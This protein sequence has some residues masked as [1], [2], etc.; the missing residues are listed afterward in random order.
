MKNIIEMYKINKI[1]DNDVYANKDIDFSVSEGEVHALVG[2]N[3]AGKSTLM[4]IL[5][6]LEKPSSGNIFVDGKETFFNSPNDAID[7]GIGMVHQNFMLIPSFTVAQNIVLAHEPMKNGFIDE[8]TTNE[9]A[10]KLSE[11][12][13]L[14]IDYKSKVSDI[15]VAEKQRTEILK[16][17][18]RNP[19]V[20]IFDEPTAV[21]TPQETISLFDALTSLV[22]IG[23]TVIFI[24]HKL[25]EVKSISHRVT[26]MRSGK[27][28][29]T[30][31]TKDVS[32]NDL[33]EMMVGRKVLFNLN[34]QKA[35][36]KETIIDVKN[37]VVAD[38]NFRDALKG[39]SFSIKAGEILGV[40]GVEGNGQRE[41]V[42]AITG[43]RKIKSGNIIIDGITLANNITPKKVRE[44]KVA[45]IP[46]DRLFNG[47]SLEASIKENLIIDRLYDEEFS[48]YSV[49]K[50][51]N[52]EDNALLSIKNFHI[53][54]KDTDTKVA[55]LSG[56]NM[57]KVIVA[58]EFTSNSKLL[59]VS[60]LT[61]G[62]D[63]GSS[64]YIREKLFEQSR[65]GCAILLVSADLAE[66]MSLSDRIITLHN[67]NISGEFDNSETID[68]K[69]LGLYM[70]GVKDM[71][72]SKT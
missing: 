71:F 41:L 20:L 4:K 14:R 24:T 38:N 68:E 5:Y 63:I 49:L 33:S 44:M 56:G 31:N 46:E 36:T 30:L 21:L 6:G 15:N 37:I 35:V 3:G 11:E 40:A 59:I 55:S 66:V 1:Y 47:V 43:I 32:E 34:K 70:L 45:H 16:A 29:T 69:E 61:R 19:K 51:K 12:Y 65:L 62:I 13:N 57:Q 42:E 17:L 72:G 22:D 64:E 2:E 54:A 48:K 50:L 8:Y 52:I 53:L 18:Y 67:G 25:K 27:K 10:R 23:K 58:R 9:I 28:I 26:V 39:V 60:Q 7:A